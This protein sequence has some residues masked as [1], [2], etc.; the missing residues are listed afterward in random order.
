[1]TGPRTD[2][3]SVRV[4]VL[5]AGGESRRMGR[6]KR[7]LRLDGETLL[8][9]N[10]AFLGGVFPV[11]GL[12]VR[13]TDQAP[14]G[15][16][17]GIVVVPDERPGSPLAGLASALGRFGEPVFAM[18][19]DLI[20]PE[21]D[22]VA[23]VL[24][25][26]MAV[27]VS[28]PVAGDHLEPLHAVYGPGCLLHM[29]RL[30]DAGAHSILDLFPLVRVA[31]VPF[32]ETAPFFNVNTPAEWTEAQRRLGRAV[33]AAPDARPPRRHGRPVVLGV[34]G[35]PNSGKT[36]LI[37]QLIREFTRR[38]LRVGAVKRVARFDIDMPGKDSWRH[39]QAGAGAYAVASAS[40]LAFV[41]RRQEEPALEEIV[42]RY[43]HGYDIVVCEGYRR[44]APD[45]VEVFRIG[46]GY[47]S[48]VCE[49]GE[50]LALVTDAGIEHERRFGLDQYS[51]LAGFLVAH[52]GLGPPA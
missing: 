44:E 18:A 49:P 1:M 33:T 47:E 37:E 14:A 34:I 43:F 27:D 38:G 16:P 10:L 50:P 25:A 36:T 2:A 31:H 12:S 3:D 28:L 22:A 46:A 29:R 13:S 35:R 24:A 19:A 21:R 51:D 32:A 30:L 48:P 6:D 7:C 11:V 5:L 26:Y 20:A 8:Q 52:L 39:S 4:G 15:L 23:R 41:E 9:R 42:A 17:G 40:K 45:V